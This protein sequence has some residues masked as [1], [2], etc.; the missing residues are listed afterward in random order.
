MIAGKPLALARDAS[1]LVGECYEL[2][3]RRAALASPSITGRTDA[4]QDFLLKVTPPRLPRNLVPRK[5]L[6]TTANALGDASVLLVQAPAGFG[7]T[8]LL[9]QWRKEIQSTGVAVAWLS[10]HTRD[11][12]HRLVQ[13]LTLAVRVAS[14][15]AAFGQAAFEFDGDDRLEHVTVF[16]AELAQSAQELVLIIHEADKLPEASREALNYLLRQAPQNLHTVIA[17][18]PDWRT[19]LD[20]LV[21]YGQCVV[22]DQR[23]LRFDID[24]TLQLVQA[25]AGA[26]IDRGI[27]ARLHVLTEGWPLGLQLALS[28][29]LRGGDASAGVSGMAVLGGELQGQLV[30]LLL[31]NLADD[32]R[33]FLVRTS[34]TTCTPIC[35]AWSRPT[36]DASD[37]LA[38]LSLDTPVFVSAEGGAW[39]RMH[40]VVRDALRERFATLP[41][42][43]RRDAHARAASWLADQ[44]L[45]CRARSWPRP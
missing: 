25:R 8:S 12:P 24:E 44:G 27:G 4:Y 5:R 16:L 10:A 18:R 17:A 39:R 33:N 23:L 29:V 43:Q 34:W 11:D 41:E 37:R 19:D 20:D 35:A 21:A 14:G 15:K 3:G 28:I 42:D 40:A 7:K 2:I 31:A 26:R 45:R 36:P 6:T 32:D 22:V 38:R 1:D 13:A 30:T 9:A